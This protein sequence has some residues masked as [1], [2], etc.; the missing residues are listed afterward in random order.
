MILA[1]FLSISNSG[2]HEFCML[3]EINQL[4]PHRSRREERRRKKEKK[5]RGE[6]FFRIDDG[7][8]WK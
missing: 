6:H 5:N 7:K 1:R 2:L 4:G 8:S 3:T